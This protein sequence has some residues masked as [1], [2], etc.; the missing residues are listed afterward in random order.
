MGFNRAIVAT[1]IGLAVTVLAGCGSSG[2]ALLSRDQASLLQA[3]LQRAS[4]A[5]DAGHCQD[6]TR[7]AGELVT[8]A[9]NLGGVDSKLVSDLVDGANRIAQLTAQDCH[10]AAPTTPPA[11]KTQTHT[12]TTVSTPTTTPSTSTTTTTT[13]TT[14]TTQTVTPPLSTSTTGGGGLNAATTP[15][16][17][18]TTPGSSSA[19]TPSTS[20]SGGAGLQGPGG[21]TSGQN[22]AA[23]GN[24]Q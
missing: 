2:S 23:G 1:G 20:A 4:G 24:Q 18:A 16:T 7:D 13:S 22:S 8:S 5:L 3:E 9:Q 11:P 17:P 6:A 21:G 19:G 10:A 12:Q 14:P 15:T